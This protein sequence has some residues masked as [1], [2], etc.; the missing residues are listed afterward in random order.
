VHTFIEINISLKVITY[1]P[2]IARRQ[3][4][5][6]YTPV[7]TLELLDIGISK[8]MKTVQRFWIERKRNSAQYV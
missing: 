2:M 3:I 8:T 1:G 5:Y 7:M 4:V 6:K